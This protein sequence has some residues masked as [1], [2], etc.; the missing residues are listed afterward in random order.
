MST[1]KKLSEKEDKLKGLKNI[2]ED[3][4]S[5]IVALSGGVDSSFLLAACSEFMEKGKLLAATSRS[6]IHP[7]EEIETAGEIAKGLGVKWRKIGTNVLEQE[8]FTSNPESRCYFCKLD[9]FR[10]LRKLAGKEG[11]QEILDGSTKD[12]EKNHRPGQKAAEELD[13]KSPLRQ[14]G[15]GKEK[16]R[17]LAEKIGL[18]N[19]DRPSGACLATRFPYGE[20]IEPAELQKLEDAEATLKD[21]GL[22]GFRLRV[23]DAGKLARLEI[24]KDQFGEVIQNGEKIVSLLEKADFTYV[25][26]DLEGYRPAGSNLKEV[27]NE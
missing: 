24:G 22:E 3:Y 1:L 17:D 13:V 4:D 11:Y 27:N 26:L 23:H 19:W 14:A 9:L 21:L 18:P 8:K 6:D 20:K 5:A 2:L 15:L 10:N 16:I 12:D 25:T 7:D